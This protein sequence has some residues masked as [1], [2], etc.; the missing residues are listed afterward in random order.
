MN[1]HFVLLRHKGALLELPPIQVLSDVPEGMLMEGHMDMGSRED[2]SGKSL[3]VR[4]RRSQ[5]GKPILAFMYKPEL[6]DVSYAH[7]KV[8][9]WEPAS[10]DGKVSMVMQ[11]WLVFPDRESR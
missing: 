2:I 7:F 3:H 8:R 1:V 9:G 11:E 10:V 5:S 4:R 6:A